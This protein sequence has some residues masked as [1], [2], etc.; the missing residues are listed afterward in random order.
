MGKCGNNSL[1]LYNS[2]DD[3]LCKSDYSKVTKWIS[4]LEMIGIIS[5]NLAVI[6]LLARRDK[7]SRMTFFVQH[8]AVADLCVGLLYVMPECIFDRFLERWEKHSCFIFYGYFT[9]LVINASTF[10]ILVLTVDRV[11]VIVRPVSSY[12]TGKTYRYGLIISAWSVAVLIAIPYAM[13]ITYY[14]SS[15]DGIDGYICRHNF[16]NGIYAVVVGEVF[17]SIVIP[18]C[19]ITVSYVWMIRVIWQREKATNFMTLNQPRL[20]KG[21][22]NI[23]PQTIRVNQTTVI[24]RAK[25]KTIK[26]LLVVVIVYISSTAPLNIAQILSVYDLI[27]PG[28]TIY[29]FLHVLAPVNSLMNPL[30]FL[31]FNKQMFSQKRG[32][33][34]HTCT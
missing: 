26:L 12:T 32:L 11:F 16:G 3:D 4:L 9:N 28:S 24:S 25:K 10:L 15:K 5:L 34:N 8:L 7:Q 14:Y 21:S 2:S 6:I 18:V 23:N 22:A 31:V 27:K 20:S 19:V 1:L 33:G 30:V 29:K 13:H 17:I